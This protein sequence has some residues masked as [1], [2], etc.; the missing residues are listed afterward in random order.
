MTCTLTH[1]TATDT[2]TCSREEQHHGGHR[3][4]DAAIYWYPT[5]EPP[6]FTTAPPVEVQEPDYVEI[7]QLAYLEGIRYARE[8]EQPSEEE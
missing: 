6:P 8:Q 3:D 2:L 1:Q 5:E 7:R 4:D